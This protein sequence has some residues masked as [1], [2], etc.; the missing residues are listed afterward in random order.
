M[1]GGGCGAELQRYKPTAA[2]ESQHLPALEVQDGEVMARQSQRRPS[3]GPRPSRQIPVV[4]EGETP[5]TRQTQ[6]RPQSAPFDNMNRP[7]RQ[8]HVREDPFFNRSS[9]YNDPLFGWL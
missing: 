3:P 9:F 5:Y 7:G 1:G 2:G 6:A 8:R 4:Y